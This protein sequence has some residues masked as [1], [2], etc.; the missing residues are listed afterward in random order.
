VRE[1]FKLVERAKDLMFSPRGLLITR[2]PS[3]FC[4][5]V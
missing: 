3:S 2:A 1:M 4:A 5:F